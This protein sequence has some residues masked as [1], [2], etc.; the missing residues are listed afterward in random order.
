MSDH[1]IEY[2]YTEPIIVNTFISG[3]TVTIRICRVSDGGFLDWSDDTFKPVGSVTTLNQPLVEKDA[4]NAPGI[5]MLASANHP[6]GLD[7]SILSVLD[8]SV[9][10]EYIIIPTVTGPPRNVVPSTL[11]LN[12]L[13]DG[14]V[15]RKTVRSRMNAMA[16]GDIVLNPP[17]PLCPTVEATY[18]DENGNPLFT[19]INDN[20]GRTT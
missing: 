13:V 4:V 5:Y 11:R 15:D 18:L 3:Q 7:T 20:T 1:E 14:V 2:G 16:K 17:G 10:D 8:P 19:N 9:D 12:C 6:L